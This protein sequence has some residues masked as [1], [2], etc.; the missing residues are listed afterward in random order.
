MP[1]DVSSTAS[2]DAASADPV[3]ASNTPQKAPVALNGA[4]QAA[5]LQVA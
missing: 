3:E 4:Y 5:A 2:L 1:T